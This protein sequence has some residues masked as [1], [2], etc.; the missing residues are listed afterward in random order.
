MPLMNGYE[1]AKALRR[2]AASQPLV[3]VALTAWGNEQSRQ[4]SKAAGFGLYLT[5]PA[6][7]EELIKISE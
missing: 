6:H 2:E 4:K 1:V 7:F 3:I 5:K